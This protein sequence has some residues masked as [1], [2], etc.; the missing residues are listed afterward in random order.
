MKTYPEIEQ[1]CTRLR[2]IRESKNLTLAQAA[3]LSRG[4]IS[5][6]ALGSYERGDRS[7]S[8]TK[9]IQIS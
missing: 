4:A 7:I 9:L 1:L 3:S 5:A 2:L 8:A 6:I